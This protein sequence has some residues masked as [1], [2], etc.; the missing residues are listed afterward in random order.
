MGPVFT[1]RDI[2]LLIALAP[3]MLI[4]AGVLWTVEGS[5]K[6]AA[7][8]QRAGRRAEK[9]GT[10]RRRPLTP[11]LS[12]DDGGG[13]HGGNNNRDTRPKRKRTYTQSQSLFFNLPQNLRT[14]IYREILSFQPI[15]LTIEHREGPGS[16]LRSDRLNAK[17]LH[18]ALSALPQG[19]RGEY[20]NWLRK[21]REWPVCGLLA[22]CRRVYAEAI[23]ILYESNTL[24]FN[25]PIRILDLSLCI[26]PSRLQTIRSIQIEQTLYDPTPGNGNVRMT[27]ERTERDRWRDACAI[28]AGMSGLQKLVVRFCSHDY[29]PGGVDV[30]PYVAAMA[31]INVPKIVVY[32]GRGVSVRSHLDLTTFK[33]GLPLM[34]VEGEL[35]R[36]IL[37]RRSG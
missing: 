5:K 11:P 13:E 36:G 7:I 31:D 25:N 21:R 12:D 37:R 33:R 14:M 19:E 28:L 17:L 6:F 8:W 27:S 18:R 10:G 16:R 30:V 2:P 22:C 29:C 35:S 24:C 3:L 32:T 4:T 15:P 26:V 34:L 23:P 1:K 20:L 9:P